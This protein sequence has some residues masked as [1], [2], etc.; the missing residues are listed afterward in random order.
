MIKEYYPIAVFKS[1]F[2]SYSSQDLDCNYST[3]KKMNLIEQGVS[4]FLCA[5]FFERANQRRYI[6]KHMGNFLV[7]SSRKSP[8]QQKQAMQKRSAGHHQVVPFQSQRT[9][10]FLLLLCKRSL[11]WL[12]SPSILLIVVAQLALWF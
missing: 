11:L 8:M 7:G 4:S 6:Q 10:E 9:F 2:R 5:D 3:K 1:W 12:T